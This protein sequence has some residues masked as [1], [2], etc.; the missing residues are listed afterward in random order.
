VRERGMQ[1]RR[2]RAAQA[3]AQGGGS[4]DKGSGTP[5]RGAGYWPAVA[6]AAIIIATAGWTTVAVMTLGGGSGPTAEAAPTDDDL[7]DASLDPSEEEPVAELHDAPELEALLP[8]DVAGTPMVT[9]SWT[10]E[11]LLQEG[12]PWS[13][14]V[15]AF[16]TESGKVPTDLKNAQAYDPEQATDYR[17]GVFRLDG[18]PAADVRDAM[19]EAWKTEYPEL[20]TSTVEL[21]GTEV[22]KGDFGEDSINSYWFIRDDLLFDVE[23]SDESIVSSVIAWLVDPSASPVAAPSAAASASPS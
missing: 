17:V 13:D 5:P 21:G 2:A 23:A 18:V 7:V 9:E 6:I 3:E 22:T 1:S 8:T 16:L 11:P 14:A 15:V 12:G 20:A 10:G 19:V 4:G